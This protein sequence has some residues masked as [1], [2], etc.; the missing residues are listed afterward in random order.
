MAIWH[1]WTSLLATSLHQLTGTVGLSPAVAIIVF[2]LLARALLAPLSFTVARRGLQRRQQLQ[3]LKPALDAIRQEH[4]GDAAA[5]SAATLALYREH[6]I[7]FLDRPQLAYLGAQAA[8]GIGSWQMLAAQAF[9][10]PFLWI[11]SLARPDA[12]LTVLVTA[13]MVA[14]M[15]ASPGM[16]LEPA[17]IAMIVV[18]TLMSA[19]VVS[20]LPA[21]LGLSWAAASVF[22]VAQG[23]ALRAVA[24]GSGFHPSHAPTSAT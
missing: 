3:A 5:Q 16:T 21:A 23:L 11:A 20:T 14:A 6:G 7:R 12:W 4:A 17:T 18:S 24:G 22:A 15:A 19:W 10:Q 1:F 2:T 9:H 8:V 13:L